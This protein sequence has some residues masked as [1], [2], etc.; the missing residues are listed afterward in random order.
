[1]KLNKSKIV[2]VIIL[3]TIGITG[4][5]YSYNDIMLE[6]ELNKAFAL[7]E[8]GKNEE[9]LQVYDS[10]IQRDPNIP[11]LYVN[12]GVILYELGRTKESVVTLSKAL[13][14]EPNSPDILY[15][16]SIALEEIDAEKASEFYELAIE[17]GLDKILESEK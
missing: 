9:A 14:Y 1:M 12:K 3:F 4:V 11:D 6:L 7:R 13:K 16:L 2:I 17:N 10:M 8:A 5:A 15:N